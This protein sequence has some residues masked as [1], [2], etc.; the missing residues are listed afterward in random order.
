MVRV[1]VVATGIDSAE[2]RAFER[3]RDADRRSGRTAARPRGGPRCRDGEGTR[4]RCRSPPSTPIP[5]A[6]SQ[7]GYRRA[8][9][10]AAD[11]RAGV[12]ARRTSSAG[13]PAG[14]AICRAGLRRAGAR[15]FRRWPV[16]SAGSGIAGRPAAAHAADRGSCRCRR[17]NRSA[18]SAV[19]RPSHFRRMT[20]RK[21]CW[22][23]SR[24][25]ASVGMKSRSAMLRRPRASQRRALPRRH[26]VW[27]SRARF[28]PNTASAFHSSLRRARSRRRSTRIRGARP[29]RRVQSRKSNWKFPAFLAAPVELTSSRASS[30]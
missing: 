30:K 28:M 26:P 18:P 16:H 22:S 2:M 24:L 5:I 14:A 13:A 17:K 23:G 6:E 9:G 12:G 29:L 3:R 7:I 11:L 25:L 19:S 10:A 20:R 8:G 15:P 27:H 1:S 21:S 4:F